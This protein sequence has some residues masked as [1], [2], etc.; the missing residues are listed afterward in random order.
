[1]DLGCLLGSTA[2]NSLSSECYG[3][4]VLAYHIPS[5]FHFPTCSFFILAHFSG[6]TVSSPRA[7]RRRQRNP[8][9][10]LWRGGSFVSQSDLDDY[11]YPTQSVA[12]EFTSIPGRAQFPFFLFLPCSHHPNSRKCVHTPP[13]GLDEESILANK[14]TPY[15]HLGAPLPAYPYKTRVGGSRS[16]RGTH[17][18]EY[19]PT[20]KISVCQVRFFLVGLGGFD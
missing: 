6:P 20:P 14:H 15:T 19:P 1:M 12:Y 7:P 18:S 11:P 9:C 5:V 2:A 17:Y 4:F 8:T 10:L 3:P 16:L 13:N